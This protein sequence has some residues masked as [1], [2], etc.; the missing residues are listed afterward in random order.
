MKGKSNKFSIYLLK[1]NYNANN[2]LKKDH[3]LSNQ[4]EA[5]NLPKNSTLYLLDNPPTVPWWKSFFGITTELKQISKGALLFIPIGSRC[6]ALSFGHAHH[7]LH[8]ESY[9]YDFG[10]KVTLNCI[11]PE[12]LKSTDI[13]APGSSRRQRI[14]LP[15]AQALTYFDFDQNTNIL[16]SLT[17]KV[18]NEY[19]EFLK[20]VTGSSSLKISLKVSPDELPEICKKLLALYSSENFKS[21][22][23][24]INNIKTVKDPNIKKQLDKSLLKAVKRKEE[25]LSLSIPEII[26]FHDNIGFS[27]SSKKNAAIYDDACIENYYEHLGIEKIDLKNIILE[28]IKSQSIYIKTND[29]SEIKKYFYIYKCLIFDTTL[30]HRESKTYHFCDGEWYEIDNN[31]IQRLNNFLDKSDYNFE[32]SLPNFTFE[33]KDQTGKLSES[34]YNQ[35]VANASNGGIICLDK[36]NIAPNGETQVEPCDL[37]SSHQEYGVL[38]HLKRSTDSSSLSHLFNQGANSIQLL[39]NEKK[40]REKFKELLPDDKPELKNHIDDFNK[41]KVVYAIITKKDSSKRSENL[42][43]FSKISL[44]RS[45]QMLTSMRIS[46]G[47]CFVK[48]LSNEELS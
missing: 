5:S 26:D 29:Q 8:D 13:L 10:L 46:A 18:K 24:N 25:K 23:P 21:T 35:A 37:Y 6:F 20:N 32:H 4:I 12:K 43:L 36:K 41:I 17:G 33:Y 44:M 16:R 2:A 40:A 15:K 45:L 3:K 34:F 19:A 30:L 11:D 7:Y 9:E 48:D 22:F 1:E 38:Y 39:I 14:Q 28:T 27:F 47:Y 42:P 31:F